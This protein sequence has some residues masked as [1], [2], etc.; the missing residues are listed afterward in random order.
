ME[1]ME[2]HNP[3]RVM[4]GTGASEDM[5]MVNQKPLSGVG[6]VRD[7]MASPRGFEPLLPP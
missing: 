3:R 5:S 7:V 6:R 4:W 2:K 1:R